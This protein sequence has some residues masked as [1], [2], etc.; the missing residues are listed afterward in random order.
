VTKRNSRRRLATI[1]LCHFVT[2][3]LC[4]LFVLASTASAQDYEI[5]LARPQKVGDLY[6][7][8]ATTHWLQRVTIISA[9]GTENHR[10]EFSGLLE[11][12]LKVLAVDARGQPT[13]LHLVVGKCVKK[14]G[15]TEQNLLPRE[16]VVM[17]AF[18]DGKTAFTVDNKPVSDE[19]MMLLGKAV[20]LANGRPTEDDFYG[21]RK[22]VKVGE[23]WSVN[24]DLAAT[25][26]SKSSPG[27]RKEDVSGAVTLASAGK[28][29]GTDVIEVTAEMNVRNL[30][31]PAKEGVVVEKASFQQKFSGK[32]PVDSA[33]MPVEVKI[34]Q[35]QTSL[36]KAQAAAKATTVSIE[37][38]VEQSATVTFTPPPGN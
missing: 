19:A 3:S 38:T 33:K 26:L 17:A 31:P 27:L 8:S 5:R 34:E 24:T 35:N 28:S 1:V 32:F 7:I 6:R 20:P 15:D 11:G 13:S 4:H 16:S 14:V 37:H 23:R 18:K 21:T 25:E 22:R 10:D 30:K 29:G 36:S 12:S 2:L 9:E